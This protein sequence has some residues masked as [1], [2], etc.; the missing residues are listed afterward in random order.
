MNSAAIGYILSKKLIDL[1]QMANS[2]MPTATRMKV[3][4]MMNLIK[5]PRH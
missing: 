3:S 5:L 1:K 4:I 2:A